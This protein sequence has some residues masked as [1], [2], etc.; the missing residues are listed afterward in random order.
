MGRFRL[1][2][3]TKEVFYLKPKTLNLAT[4][5]PALYRRGYYGTNSGN[6]EGLSILTGINVLSGTL[7]G[8]LRVVV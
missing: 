1:W 2:C 7:L 3:L 6:Y 8:L 4:R 5:S